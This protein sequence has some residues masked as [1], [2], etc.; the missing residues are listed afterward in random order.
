LPC[1]VQRHQL[2]LHNS[3]GHSILPRSPVVKLFCSVRTS[4]MRLVWPFGQ[5]T[6]CSVSGMRFTPFGF[7]SAYVGQP[8]AGFAKKHST[9]G[10]DQIQVSGTSHAE[11]TRRAVRGATIPDVRVA[12]AAVEKIIRETEL[13]EAS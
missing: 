11:P 8:L 1:F 2:H 12:A 9:N 3:T 13:P 4:E 6:V 10:E 7:L 5:V